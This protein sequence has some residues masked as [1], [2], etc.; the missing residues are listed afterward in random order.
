[1]KLF[2]S[3]NIVIKGYSG[4][5]FQRGDHKEGIIEL[6]NDIHEDELIP[7]IKQKFK[8]SHRMRTG[9]HEIVDVNILQLIN[10]KRLYEKL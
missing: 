3:C 4:T 10:I 8:D 7:V 1:M 5:P 6:P 2:C 9:D